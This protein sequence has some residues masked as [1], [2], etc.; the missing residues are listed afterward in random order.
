MKDM[1]PNRFNK[2]DLN[3]DRKLHANALA[4]SMYGLDLTSIEGGGMYSVKTVLNLIDYIEELK[5]GS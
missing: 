3:D 1:T 2:Y 5:Y 4:I